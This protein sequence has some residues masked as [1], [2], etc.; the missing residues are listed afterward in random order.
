MSDVLQ[1]EHDFVIQTKTRHRMPVVRTT[2]I[3]NVEETSRTGHTRQASV[4]RVRVAR[5]KRASMKRL[6]ASPQRRESGSS[7]GEHELVLDNR[8]SE[9]ETDSAG[10]IAVILLFADLLSSGDRN[11]HRF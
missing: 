6:K 7:S 4:D 11:S 2:S 1:Y 10:E 9:T 8:D 5:I 3:T